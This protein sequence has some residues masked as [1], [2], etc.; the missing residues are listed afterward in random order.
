M[1][2]GYFGIGVFHG[3]NEQ[4]IGTLWRS[5]NIMGADFIF[6]IGKRYS[7]QC[8][9]RRRAINELLFQLNSKEVK[10][11]HDPVQLSVTDAEKIL[12][13]LKEQ[14]AVSV[15][16]C[17]QMFTVKYGHCPKCNEGLNSEVYPHWCGFCG[18]AMKWNEIS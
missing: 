2:R 6:T 5:A 10:E 9:D 8:T 18:Q 7:R 14:E 13:L 3:K 1:K 4:N 16:V 12:A 17:G 11:H 15:D